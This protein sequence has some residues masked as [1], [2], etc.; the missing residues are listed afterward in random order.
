MTFILNID[1]SG[2][3][4]QVSISK[5]GICVGKISNA[6]QKEHASFLQPAIKKL[7]QES[8][9]HLNQLSAIAVVNGPGSYTGLRVGLASAKGICYAIGLPLLT[10]NTLTL[11][12]RSAQLQ[13]QGGGNSEVL[14]CPMIDA[15][16]MEVYTALYDGQLKEIIFPQAMILT[17]E[18]FVD[19]LLQAPVLF[20]GDGA[21]KMKSITASAN[22]LFAGVY[23][24]NTAL[25]MMAFEK[26]VANDV[27]NLAYTE[28]FYLKEFFD[29]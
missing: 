25:C 24:S 21:F 15:R 23:D 13:Y 14:F 8:R 27:A 12:A 17:N 5:D 26:F 22:A 16:R 1:T 19:F 29:K 18:S 9:L 2:S 4:A 6:E 3:A 7:L 11:M 28:P 20:F 10:I